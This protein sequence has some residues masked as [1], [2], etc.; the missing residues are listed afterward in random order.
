MITYFP[1]LIRILNEKKE[2]FN[3]VFQSKKKG[4]TIESD[5]SLKATNSYHL[6]GVHTDYD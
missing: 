6:T 2:G 4:K 1:G 3:Q 5:K